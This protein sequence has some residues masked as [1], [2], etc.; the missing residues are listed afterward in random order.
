M[1]QQ[2]QQGQQGQHQQ[3]EQGQRANVCKICNIVISTDR[4]FIVHFKK[5]HPDFEINKSLM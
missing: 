2:D 3:Q 1:N 5:E 4:A